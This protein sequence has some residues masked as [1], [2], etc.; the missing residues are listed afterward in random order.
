MWRLTTRAI[1][2]VSST[3]LSLPATPR[4]PLQE[5]SPQ[6]VKLCCNLESLQISTLMLSWSNTTL[7]VHRLTSCLLSVATAVSLSL[8][9]RSDWRKVRS[10]SKVKAHLSLDEWTDDHDKMCRFGNHHA[11]VGAKSASAGEGFLGHPQ[12]SEEAVSRLDLDIKFSRAVALLSAKLMPLW[13]KLDLQDAVWIAPPKD[14]P[15]VGNS[16]QCDWQPIQIPELGSVSGFW[17]CSSCGKVSRL[18]THGPPPPSSKCVPFH[19]LEA[20][21]LEARG[22]RCIPLSCSDNSM[23]V[24]CTKC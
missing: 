5:S 10:L 6:S 23:L 12:P 13:P 17:K 21:V 3:V 1:S 7:I 24:I 11:D 14:P 9:L 4:P 8:S 15:Q 18:P 16:S 2:W 19:G 20:R 22:H